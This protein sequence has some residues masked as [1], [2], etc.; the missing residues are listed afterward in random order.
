MEGH[1]KKRLGKTVLM[2][3]FF[4]FLTMA[5]ASPPLYAT[6]PQ[7]VKLTYDAASQSLQVTI[8]H[9]SPFP[10]FHY[11]KKVEVK[12]NNTGKSAYKYESQPAGGQF[13]YTYKL[14]A[15]S[16]GTIEVEAFC[17]LYGSKSETINIL[18]K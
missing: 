15:G 1:G 13:T 18:R 5:V 4:F 7:D 12:I 11:I 10:S 3:L 2:L 6:P 8:I 9:P 17:S 16:A 14:P